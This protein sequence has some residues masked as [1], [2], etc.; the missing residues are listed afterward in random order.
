MKPHRLHHAAIAL[1]LAVAGCH[2]RTTAPAPEPDLGLQETIGREFV[3]KRGCPTC[4]QSANAADGIL[5]GQLAAQPGTSAYPGNLTSDVATGLGGWA[6]IEIVRA[7]RYGIDPAQ[8]ALCPPMPHF[9]GSDAQQ[10]AMT[11]VEADAIIA[12]LRSLQAV[13]RT[14]PES[15]CPPIK[16]SPAAD[17]SAAAPAPIADLGAA[18]LGS[19]NHD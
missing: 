4:H 3:A 14:I 5:S 15:T 12:Y 10:P 2:G 19:P 7:M 9:D 11:D 6:D 8:E 1:L 16:P 18:D 13:T 17:L